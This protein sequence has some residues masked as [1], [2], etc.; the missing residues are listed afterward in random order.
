METQKYIAQNIGAQLVILENAQVRV[1]ALDLRPEWMIG[2]VDPNSGRTPD[3]PFMS[4]IVSREHGWLHCVEG[5]W[6]FVDN[7]KNL[8]GTYHNGRKI[9]RP[10]PGKKKNTPLESG[11]ILRIDSDDLNRT[12]E[13]GVLM[14]FTTASTNGIWEAMQLKTSGET[15]IGRDTACDI[16]EELPY[17]SAKHAKI[18]WLNGR[19]YLSDCGSKAGTYV[20]GE[21][22]VSTYMLKEK[23]CIS[24]CDRSYFFTGNQLLYL[25]CNREKAQEELRMTQPDQRPVILKANIQCKKVKNR[26]GFGMKELIRDINL[27]IREGTL[28]A[29]LGTAGAGKSTVMNCMN[30]MDLKGVQGSV[31]YRNVDLMK[32]L[33]QMKYL[34]GNVPQDKIFHPELTPE[35]E[36]YDAA[37][38]RLP[39][40][41][42]KQEIQQR[43][44]KTL[45]MLSMTKV[46]NNQNSMLSGGEKTRVNV[47]IELVADRDILFLDEPDQGLS[48]NYKEELFLILRDLA[49]VHGKSILSIIHDVSK[50]ELFDQVIMLAKVDG[51]GRL[52]FSG[53]PEEACAHFGVTTIADAY[54]LLDKCPEKYVR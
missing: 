29:L 6:Y 53:T 1:C 37:L 19:Y 3:I 13:N 46:R 44:D 54:A 20:N 15:L 50:I 2:R 41:M 43:V 51:V 17:F 16:V 18:T 22:V 39:G 5:Q 12:N 31:V 28:V 14:L 24:I 27:E 26:S 36:F 49:H 40:D 34:I 9:E 25:K 52:A 33:T 35:K 10:L 30:G 32:H 7:P 8:N 21:Q 23:D 45:E 42:S 11:D 4:R 48:P 38:L 47:G